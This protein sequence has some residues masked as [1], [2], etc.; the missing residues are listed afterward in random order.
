MPFLQLRFLN[1]EQVSKLLIADV[2]INIPVR[3]IAQA[4]SYIVP[5]KLSFLERGWRV[6]VPFAGRKEE[7]FVIS[8]SEKE[9]DNTV[10]LKEIEATADDAPWFTEKMIE[11]ARWLS[12]FYLCSPAEAMRL[13]IPGKSGV[14]IKA[15]ATSAGR[16]YQIKSRISKQIAKYVSPKDIPAEEI[17]KSLKN[18]KAQLRLWQYLQDNGETD[19]MKLKAEKFSLPVI[20]ALNDSGYI[21]IKEKRVFRDSYGDFI[22][23]KRNEA[24][25][26]SQQKAFQI[27][28][29]AVIK[30]TNRKFLLHGVTGSGKTRVYIEI[31]SAVRKQGRQAIILVPEIALTGQTVSAF[32][33][34]FAD[35]IVVLH[36]RLT[37]AERNDAIGRIKR[38]EVNIAIGARSALFVPFADIGAIILD[39]EQDTSYKQEENPA[40]NARAVAEAF[41]DIHSSVLVLGSAT[42]SLES[43]YRANNGELILL[44]LPERID[45]KLLPLVN[46][47]DM[48]QELKYG[49]RHIISRELEKLITETIAKK[50]QLI[51]MLNRRGFSTFIMCRSCGHIITCKH[52][53]MPLVYHVDGRL[54]CHHCDV[55]GKVPDICPKCGST[56]IKYFGSGTEKLE[57]ELSQLVPQA[58]I[59][60]MDRDT[61]IRKDAHRKILDAFRR[62]EYDILLGTQMV[63]KGHDIPNVTAVGIISADSCLNMPDFRAAERCFMLITQ[64]AGRAGRGRTAG[65]VIVQSYNPEHYAVQA[66]KTH[67]YKDFYLQE[68]EFRKALNYPPYCRLVKIIVRDAEE[69]AARMFGDEIKRLFDMSINKSSGQIIGPFPALIAKWRE[70]YRFCLLIKTNN[71]SAVQKFLR[72]NRLNQR[73]EIMID[74]DPITIN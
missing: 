8:I 18:K 17:K 55:T 43:Y 10:V 14:K 72:A 15:E 22:A 73:K 36:S 25:T 16:N 23:E 9:I 74:I 49:N 39:E 33:E 56:Y 13:F 47:V 27:V 4:Y 11:Q 28:N 5:D 32:K 48:R 38:G 41:A 26:V 51:I 66:A 19:I 71:L 69:N 2:F 44:E 21:D 58:R 7:G 64:T 60:R 68:M 65:R 3:R 20:K 30:K 46:V 1:T 42:P 61:T 45:N 35:D 12:E 37:I 53:G 24:L 31:A 29:E 70:Y 40:Y 54:T 62:Q 34:Y 67:A 6:I 57:Q 50:E 63:A 52:C 59:I